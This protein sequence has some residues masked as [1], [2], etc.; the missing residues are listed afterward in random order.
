MSG[1]IAM[2]MVTT[3]RITGV[4]LPLVTVIAATVDICEDDWFATASNITL[5]AVELIIAA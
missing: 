2:D 3:L 5:V 1:A 4:V